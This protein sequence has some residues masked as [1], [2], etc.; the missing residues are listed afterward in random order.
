MKLLISGMLAFSF[1]FSTTTVV[2]AKDTDTKNDVKE[3]ATTKEA[4]TKEGNEPTEFK[5]Y[6]PKR[7]NRGGEETEPVAGDSS[8]RPF[9]GSND[10]RVKQP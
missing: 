4:S 9:S 3:P 2:F 7:Q 10:I 6:D 8:R 5:E 1:I